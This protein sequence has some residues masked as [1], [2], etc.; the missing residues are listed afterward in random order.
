MSLTLPSPEIEGIRLNV[1]PFRADAVIGTMALP[2]LL[3]V[4][5]SPRNQ[6]NKRA[7]RYQSGLQQRNAELRGEVQ[8]M[9]ASTSKGKNIPAYAHYIAAGIKGQHGA[10]WSTPP[11]TLWLAAK[12]GAISDELTSGAN[13][14]SMSVTPG[15]A[16]IAVDGE[17][18]VS[19]WHELYDKP[20]NY[21]LDLDRLAAVRI[22]FE[23]FWNLGVDDA[24]QIFYDRNVEGVS[25]A[26]NL[27][28]SMD[29]RDFCTQ[30]TRRLIES[31]EVEHNG[32]MEPFADFVDSKGR[33][34]KKSGQEFVTLSALRVLIATAL[35]GRRGVQHSSSTVR[36]DGLP[37]GVSTERV[38][39]RLLPLLS[40]LLSRLYPEFIARST[41]SQPAVLAGIGIAVHQATGWASDDRM[42]SEEELFRLLDSVRW[43]REARYWDGV[44]ASANANGVLN[45]GGGAKD[46]GGRVADALL[47]PETEFGRKIRGW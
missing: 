25:V 28:M 37:E 14:F 20:E 4:V 29:Q 24:R 11:V 22:P 40:R 17:T 34:L 27:A 13:V 9:I 5:P 15:S 39:R 43:E 18:Q 1:M 6:E 47:H 36:E 2:T 44:A 10:G 16:V 19:A 23:L 7:L 42:L 31:V 45:F 38:S 3:Q 33:Q 46:T 41:V 8:R 21:G 30:L 26:K 35:H 12:P 32:S